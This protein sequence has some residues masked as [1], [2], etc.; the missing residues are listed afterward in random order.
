[1]KR[2][3]P[4]TLLTTLFLSVPVLAGDMGDMKMD[5][6]P[7]MGQMMPA[8]KGVGTVKAIDL[9]KGTITISHGAVPSANWPAM[10]MTF[11]IAQDLATGIQ[12]GQRVEFEFVK[13]GKEATVKKI[14]A[15]K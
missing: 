14:T 9:A 12:T 7:G 8:H 3:I 1:M 5:G 11:K 2:V 13:Q 4:V 6:Q 15:A 10:T